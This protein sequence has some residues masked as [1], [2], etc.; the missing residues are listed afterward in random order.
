MSFGMLLPLQVIIQGF[1]SYRDQTII[2]PFSPK[3]NIIG[4]YQY[5]LVTVLFKSAAALV[6]CYCF[7]IVAAVIVLGLGV[8]FL[9]FV[10]LFP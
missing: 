1:R 3:H 7:I 5:L 8:L 4:R 10:L 2:E 9:F 6:G